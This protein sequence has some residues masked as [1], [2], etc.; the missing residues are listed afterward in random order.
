MAPRQFLLRGVSGRMRLARLPTGATASPP[1]PAMYALKPLQMS[2]GASAGVQFDLLPSLGIYAEPGLSY[3][4]DNGSRTQTIYGD[5][6]LNLSLDFGV[7][8]TIGR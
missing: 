1:L 4:F 7:R 3:Y 8:F 5:H 2:V 6:P